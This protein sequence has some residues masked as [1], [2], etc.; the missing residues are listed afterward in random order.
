MTVLILAY[1]FNETLVSYHESANNFCSMIL[2]LGT[3][4]LVYIFDIGFIIYSYS[5]WNIII[6]IILVVFFILFTRGIVT[7][8]QIREDASIL[9][10]GIVM[11]YCIYL[12]YSAMESQPGTDVT[13]TMVLVEIMVGIFFTSLTLF[14]ITIVFRISEGT[15][16][17]MG[18]HFV[19]DP[20]EVD[21]EDLW[22]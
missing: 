15:K 12:G 21:E 10:N 14:G 5:I 18:A 17:F 13:D 19:D 8:I 16:G 4:L 1:I 20:D 9:T 7:G 11:A 6:L 3:T 22:G 2:L